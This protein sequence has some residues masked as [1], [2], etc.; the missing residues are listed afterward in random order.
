MGRSIVRDINKGITMQQQKH[1]KLTSFLIK[2]ILNLPTTHHMSQE[3]TL[4]QLTSE[5]IKKPTPI[6]LDA[7]AHF[8][9]DIL[10]LQEGKKE[11]CLPTYYSIATGYVLCDRDALQSNF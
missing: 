2:D 5:Y 9:R 1:A 3:E 10:M 8:P 7:F 6:K 11:H 4:R